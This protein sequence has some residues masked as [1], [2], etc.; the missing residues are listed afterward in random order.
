[1]A[2]ANVLAH[3][4]NEMSLAEDHDVVEDLATA[5]PDPALSSSVQVLTSG[6]IDSFHAVVFLLSGA[7]S[8]S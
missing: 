4:P 2:V 3:E 1:M 6:R 8:M 5:G 7:G